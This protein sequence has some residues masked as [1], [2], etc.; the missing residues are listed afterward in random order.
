MASE[1]KRSDTET[2]KLKKELAALKADITS[3][4][5]EEVEQVEKYLVAKVK[6]LH[7]DGRA[8]EGCSFEG[9]KVMVFEAT[10]LDALKWKAI[11]PHFTT[12]GHPAL[13]SASHGGKSAPAPIAR[14]PGGS[15]GGF[16]D[17]LAF[18]RMKVQTGRGPL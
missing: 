16:D 13:A 5:F 3:Y 2:G 4:E 15:S 8:R 14:F 9:S 18:A 10:V 7:P 1:K 6:Y 11:D 17:A 12:L